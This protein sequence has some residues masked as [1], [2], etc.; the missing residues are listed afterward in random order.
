VTADAD[1]SVTA[2]RP[3]YLYPGLIA[4][5]AVNLLFVGFLV[6]AFWH[7]LH[8]PAPPPPHARGFMGFV[9]QLAPDRQ[10]TIG[11]QVLAARESMKGLRS[12]VRT[13]WLDANALLSAEP[14]DKEKFL[15]ALM[16]VRS[17]E[18]RFKTAIYNTVANTAGELTPDERK[19]LQKWREKRHARML[20][21]RPDKSQ[22]DNKPD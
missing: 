19:L 7:H 2:T 22:D 6:T 21:P 3:R 10:E 11:K 8:E 17:A 15:A 9:N 13:S 1:P 14:F 4:S 5:L 16:K 12:D 20:A 18:D